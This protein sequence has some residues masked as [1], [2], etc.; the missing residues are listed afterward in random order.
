VIIYYGPHNGENCAFVERYATEIGQPFKYVSY[1]DD[2]FKVGA[3]HIKKASMV[4]I[5]NGKQRQGPLAAELCRRHGIPHAYYEWGFLPQKETYWV[6]PGDRDLLL[7]DLS[8][9]CQEDVDVFLTQKLTLQQACPLSP[10]GHV[11]V[12]LQIENDTSIL[13][14]TPYA[15]MDEFVADIAAMYPEQR[16]VIRPHPKSGA[17]RIVRNSNHLVDGSGTWFEACSK[18]SAVVGLTSTSLVESAL[19]GVPTFALGDCPLR[20]HGRR[21]LDRL[22]AAYLALRVP[23]SGSPKAVLE[24]F[25]LRPI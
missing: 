17:T 13:Y 9:V 6:F 1:V 11:L 5:W 10:Q 3:T 16:V 22:L 4:F 19:L 25:G 8:W 15:G 12:P 21:H 24:R 7:Q 14:T 20:Y 18:A 2:F 23:R